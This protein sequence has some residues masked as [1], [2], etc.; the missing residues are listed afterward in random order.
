[1]QDK[2]DNTIEQTDI[3]S[4]MIQNGADPNVTDNYNALPLHYALTSLSDESILL[5]IKSTKD[6]D[7]V[8]HNKVRCIHLALKYECFEHIKL[9]LDRDIRIFTAE[10][11]E[12]SP[13]TYKQL[14]DFEDDEDEEEEE[15]EEDYFNSS[16]DDTNN[17]ESDE[18]LYNT[19]DSD[20]SEDT[21][22]DSENNIMDIQ[23]DEKKKPKGNGFLK[24]LIDAID[25]NT[26][27]SGTEK[28]LLKTILNL[29]FM[30]LNKE[31]YN[32]TLVDRI[33]KLALTL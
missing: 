32:K 19:D 25:S 5:L 1:M 27:L 31:H 3:L 4:Y 12:L 29:E 20:F 30:E 17:Y 13:F 16:I 2:L 22:N 18:I 14:R 6:I 28:R 11:Q 9:L 8:P 24:F 23:I 15:E 7:I 21:D 33:K 26:N 10:E